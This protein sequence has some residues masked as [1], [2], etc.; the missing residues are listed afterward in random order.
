MLISAKRFAMAAAMA[1][2]SFASF[3]SASATD[4]LTIGSDAPALNVEHW[5]QD[6][7]GKFK[8]VT[9]FEKGK[10]YVVEFWATWCGPCIA[11]MPHLAELQKE[12]ADKGVQLISI[13]DEDL[14]TVETFLERPVPGEEADSAEG[15]K[16]TYRELTSTYCL[17]TD[18]DQSSSEDY[19]RAAGQNGIPTSFVVGKDSKIEWIGHPMELDAILKAVVEDSWDREA[20]AAEFTQKQEME[21][22]M[23]SLGG[24]VQA[25]QFD[26]A[27]EVIEGLAKKNDS[28]QIKMMKLQVLLMAKK[29]DAS[30]E[31][32]QAMYKAI[33]DDPATVNMLAWNLFEMTA[34]MKIEDEALSAASIAATEAAA[35]KAEKEVKASILDTLA[36]YVFKKG[37]IDKAIALETEALELSGPRDREFIENFLEELKAAKAKK[38]EPKK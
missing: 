15:E 34:Q 25:Q 38:E 19:M 13:S 20:F 31:H 14:K 36:H 35:T 16:K 26:E 7:S 8:P 32:V 12:Y 18:P 3:H 10:V 21:L 17:T 6:G 37:D 4:V 11:S 27:L 23:Q 22:A 2:L 33:E 9:K 29:T 1:A 30:V 5:V 28:F 24:L